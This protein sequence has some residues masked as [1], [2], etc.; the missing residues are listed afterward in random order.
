[1]CHFSHVKCHVSCVVC[2]VSHVTCHISLM[3]T[4][5]AIE[6]PPAN[7]P[8]MQSRLVCKDQKPQKILKH[9]KIIK[10]TENYQNNKNPKIYRCRPILA[11]RPSTISLQ[12]TRKQ[13]CP[14]WHRQTNT[15]TTDG[16]SDLE[17]L[18]ASC[19]IQ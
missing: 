15:H 3:P 16:H 18:W 7:S 19:P 1:M 2:L 4:A 5:T 10:T 12:S 9:K 17:T 14:R 11:V 13:V 6:H 8:N